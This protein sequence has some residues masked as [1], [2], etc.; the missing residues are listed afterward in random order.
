MD[1]GFA[2]SRTAGLL[3]FASLW[4][5][6]FAQA[7]SAELGNPIIRMN[8][9]TSACCVMNCPL[10]VT[11]DDGTV[12]PTQY[13]WDHANGATSFSPGYNPN[14]EGGEAFS[15]LPSTFD[16]PMTLRRQLG[17]SCYEPYS[18]VSNTVI[19]NPSAGSST[20]LIITAYPLY[21]SNDYPELFV[22]YTSG[23]PVR[24][25]TSE[26]GTL[27]CTNCYP[28]ENNLNDYKWERW[29]ADGSYAGLSR[30]NT[31][32]LTSYCYTQLNWENIA[33]CYGTCKTIVVG[34]SYA[35]YNARGDYPNPPSAITII[36]RSNEI[37]NVCKPKNSGCT[38]GA[39][40]CCPGLDCTQIG[41]SYKCLA[42]I[43]SGGTCDA[44][45]PCCS[46]LSCIGGTC[47]TCANEGQ[48]CAGAGAGNCCSGLSCVAGTGGALTC[49]NCRSLRQGCGGASDPACC[50]PLKCDVGITPRTCCRGAGGACGAQN[51]CCNGLFCVNGQCN[52]CGNAGDDCASLGAGN[53]CC[54][55]QEPPLFCD[56]LQPAPAARECK[57]CYAAGERC[58]PGSAQACCNG[59]VCEEEGGA[60]TCQAP[61]LEDATNLPG[62]MELCVLA[63][64][65]TMMLVALAYMAGEIMQN[66]KIIMWAKTEALQAVVS[67]A[68]VAAILLIMAAFSQA[69]L[70][71][72]FGIF[73]LGV[74]GAFAGHESQTV[75]GGAIVY[76]ERL[77]A[78]GLANI[79]QIRYDLGAYE[80]RT[81]YTEYSC[82]GQCL[83][84]L[85]SFNTLIYG[86]ETMNLAVA[87]NLLSTA[88]V[89]YLSIV[90][91]YFTLQFIVNGLFAVF[92]PIAIVMRAIPFMRGF[93]GAM[94]GIIVALYILYPA[95][96]VLDSALAPSL[97]AGISGGSGLVFDNRAQGIGCDQ[98]GNEVFG[99]GN[100]ACNGGGKKE[101]DLKKVGISGSVMESLGPSGIDRTLRLNVLM[102]LAAV[103]LPALNFIVIAALAR[104]ISRV[105]GEEADIGKLGQMV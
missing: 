40:L 38:P 96:I 81:T 4:L 87:N 78:M 41:A 66:P 80:I 64:I 70:A 8:S 36:H 45:N 21:S 14:C 97:A 89:S 84:T 16:N 103:F 73:G 56:A 85:V 1:M 92:L 37:Y 6:L 69:N 29:Y 32:H 47:Q 28:L 44:S 30:D 63:A 82:Q 100:V 27:I 53:T 60:H 46:G 15:G 18:N 25:G 83:M 61:P 71:E 34:N 101:D 50:L 42:C 5:A 52:P 39:K 76:L 104:D 90:F 17:G 22:G 62:M 94:I 88:T 77:G 31:Y 58:Q 93:G 49:Q 57:T 95:M 68:S 20:A 86:G 24:Y 54:L 99:A 23:D 98:T 75:Y 26:N 10:S 12:C 51:D 3:L 67:V 2:C 13:T 48:A 59:L 105:L 74:P 65:G 35:Y 79:A 91:Q 33:C 19:T 7:A 11:L 72:L 102:F 43:N 9:S 55:H